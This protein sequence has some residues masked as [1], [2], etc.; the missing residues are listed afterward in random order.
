MRELEIL[1]YFTSNPCQLKG[2]LFE[3]KIKI[4]IIHSLSGLLQPT[5]PG[6]NHG[7]VPVKPDPDLQTRGKVLDAQGI[8]QNR[9]SPVL[10]CRIRR[11]LGR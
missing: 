9:P 11:L 8:E 1:K 3:K 4:K 10:L 5:G 7:H 6:D 2:T